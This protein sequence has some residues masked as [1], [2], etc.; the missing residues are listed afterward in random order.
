MGIL[1]TILNELSYRMTR[2]WQ[3]LRKNWGL[4]DAA[5]GAVAIAAVCALCVSLFR[6]RARKAA[7]ETGKK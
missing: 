5:M 6:R 4:T 2:F 1:V 7:G 3:A